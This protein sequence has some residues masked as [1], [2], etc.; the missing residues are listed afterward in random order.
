MVSSEDG[1]LGRAA[2]AGLPAG[3]ALTPSPGLSDGRE[4]DP[5][6]LRWAGEAMV[7]G[8]AAMA[9]VARRVG[10]AGKGLRVELGAIGRAAERDMARADGGR[11]LHHGAL[12]PLGLLVAGA[13]LAPGGTPEEL[14]GFARQIAAHPDPRAPRTPTIGSAMSVRF[15]AAGAKGEARAGFPHVRRALDALDAARRGGAREPEA[16]LR[17]LLVV[18]TTLQD[19]GLLHAGG[20]HGLREV[21]DGAR[22]VVEGRLA[23][24]DF[25]RRLRERGLSPRGSGH[26]LA[27]ALFL[28]ALRG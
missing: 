22:G 20:P 18:M 11:G 27:A 24:D 23:L 2:V 26:L 1:R 10:E 17:A 9:A 14:T 19:T 8:L 7:P 5:G 21:Q 3:A 6:A 16:R 13:A 15:G 28:D 12:W 4:G 25:D